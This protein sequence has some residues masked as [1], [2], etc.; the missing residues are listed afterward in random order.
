MRTLHRFPDVKDVQEEC[1]R[2]ILNAT[3]TQPN[4]FGKLVGAIG[5]I[6]AILKTMTTFPQ[7]LNLQKS[8]IS[9]ISNLLFCRKENAKRLVHARE[10]EAVVATMTKFPG[11]N[12]IQGWGWLLIYNCIEHLENRDHWIELDALVVVSRA[13]KN[14]REHEEVK[15]FARKALAALA[16]EDF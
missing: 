15:R 10:P 6:E 12:E 2:V 3:S 13:I 4:R 5:T 14:H 8:A 9:A 7:S 1:C 11:D 16:G